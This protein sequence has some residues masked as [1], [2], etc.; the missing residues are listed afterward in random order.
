MNTTIILGLLGG[1]ALFLYGMQMMSSGLES[2]AGN[3]MK[4]I[5]EKLTSNRFLGVLV[6]AVITAAIQSSSATTVMVV[7]FVN[8]GMMSLNQA[9]WIIMGANIGTTI[10]GQLIALDIGAMAPLIAFIGVAFITFS[11]KPKV[12]YIG[13]ILA[14]LGILFIGMNM[15][16]ESMMPLRD[17]PPFINIMTRFSNPAVGILAGMV[18][19]AVIQSSSASVGILQALALSGVISLRNAAFVLFGQNI[20]TCITAILAS[21]GTERSA[22]RTT[23]IH[24]MFNMIG[25]II[26]TTACL[27]FPITDFVAAFSGSNLSRQIA[28]MHTLFNITTSILLIPFGNQLA[29]LAVKILPE[30]EEE[31]E[32]HKHLKYLKE[33]DTSVDATI[34][35]SAIYMEGMRNE[36]SRMLKMA[37]INV[38]KSFHAFLDGSSKAL[39]EV[40]KR[41]EYID[42]LNKAIS[43]S[44]SKMMIHETNEKNSKNI[45]SYFDMTGNIERIGDHAVNICDYTKQIEENQVVFS[46]EALL[47]IEEMRNI[48][49]F[50]FENLQKKPEDTKRWLQAVH[51][52]EN[53]IDRK[54][55]EFYENHLERIK[56]GK[57]SDEACI[58]FSE[59][60]TDF[61]RIGDH[62]WNV[63]KQIGKI[64]ERE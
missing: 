40:E 28:N 32:N 36:I 59:M 24:L 27:L 44:I 14:G 55:E 6:G 42:Y 26:F 47:E 12:Q 60:L 61:E 53:F 21:I 38:E 63:A 49:T 64:I 11:K 13:Q 30:K 52:S 29:A 43:K 22:K 54:T 7:G 57:C 56:Q 4:E 20:G 62:L 2:A 33:V 45:G 51:D 37:Q 34:G 8:S 48:C 18:F 19:T 10:T 5:L 3:K 58:I 15:M 1:L 17:Y 39:E 16:S 9:V 25:T 35:T 31:K 23:I 50:M 46:K 41:E